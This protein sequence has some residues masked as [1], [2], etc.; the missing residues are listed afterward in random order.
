MG[1]RSMCHGVLVGWATVGLFLSGVGPAHGFAQLSTTVGTFTDVV[2]EPNEENPERIQLHGVFWSLS[3]VVDPDGSCAP[4][5]ETIPGSGVDCR[6]APTEGYLYYWCDPTVEVPTAS[7]NFRPQRT[8]P[9]PSGSAPTER[10][11]SMS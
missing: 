7:E 8:G 1:S 5:L 2:W 3:W 9:A 6:T 10:A 4:E 11:V